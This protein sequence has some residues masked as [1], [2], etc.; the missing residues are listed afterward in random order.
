MKKEECYEN[1]PFW[2]VF[3]SNLLS[4]AIF[5][6]GGF[7]VY[8]LGI[9]WLSLYIILIIILE[10]RLISSH[11]PDCYYYGKVCAFGMGKVSSLFFKKG[12]PS[13]FC[14]NKMTWKSLI[15]DFMISLIPLIIGI[16]LLIKSFSLILLLSVLILFFLS[17]FGN[18]MVR[19]KL[20]CKYC[21]QKEMG[22][23]AQKFFEK[24]K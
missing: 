9:I 16:I 17:F 6:I 12:N 21:R 14:K 11:C 19:G 15:L 2:T 18:G 4:L 22:C 5:L 3:F 8:K 10:L 13:K 7:I 24:K 1:Y 23:P 20:A